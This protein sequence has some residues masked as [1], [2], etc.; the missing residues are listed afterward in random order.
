VRLF[1]LEG[2]GQSNLRVPAHFKWRQIRAL[3]AVPF[4]NVI[5]LG[6]VAIEEKLFSFSDDMKKKV[7]IFMRDDFHAVALRLF[8]NGSVAVKEHRP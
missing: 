8:C 3:R 7:Q 6:R 5:P 1:I 2:S 4:L